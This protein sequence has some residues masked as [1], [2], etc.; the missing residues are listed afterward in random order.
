MTSN[1]NNNFNEDNSSDREKKN[2]Y[3]DR[4]RTVLQN[5]IQKLDAERLQI[6]SDADDAKNHHT[7]PSKTLLNGASF[8]APLILALYAIDP[9]AYHIL[10]V[11]VADIVLALI[12]Y[13]IYIATLKRINKLTRS[14]DR[15]Y[16]LTIEKL[17]YFRDYFDMDTYDVNSFTKDKIDRFYNLHTFA[18]AAA[19]WD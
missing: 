19:Q 7:T 9:S 14:I 3:I 17:N 16:L 1:A 11:F 2:W 6:I 18:S 5:R 13:R 8:A 4:I 10:L 15:A 12:M